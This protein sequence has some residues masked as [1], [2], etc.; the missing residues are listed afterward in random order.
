M[1][2]VRLEL[3]GLGPMTHPT[4][5]WKDVDKGIW[6]SDSELYAI[7]E[8]Y[9]NFI[10]YSTECAKSFTA[11]VMRLSGNNVDCSLRFGCANEVM[12]RDYW[13]DK[14]VDYA[15]ELGFEIVEYEVNGTYEGITDDNG[16]ITQFVYFDYNA[17][18]AA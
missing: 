2:V 6:D 8:E 14:F 13:G 18:I 4:Y 9:L 12:L 16:D 3:D 1:K 15:L 11:S 10:G 7:W 17:K 5:G